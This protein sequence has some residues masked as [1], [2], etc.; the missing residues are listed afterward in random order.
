MDTKTQETIKCANCG[1]LNILS[2]MEKTAIKEGVGESVEIV[3]EQVLKDI[4]KI[5]K[6][7]K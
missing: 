3:K 5:F 4:K 1:K 2:V 6:K 7:N